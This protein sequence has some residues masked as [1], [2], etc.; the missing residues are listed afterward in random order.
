MNVGI[1]GAGN[2]GRAIARQMVRA[3][4]A[5]IISNR[6]GPASLASVVR[7]LGSK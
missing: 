7:E 4:R 5:V 2:I 3:E 6:R 1:I